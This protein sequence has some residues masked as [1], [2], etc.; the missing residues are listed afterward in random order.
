MGVIAMKATE[1]SLTAAEKRAL[2][3]S[4]FGLPE[5]RGWPLHDESHVRSAITNF[6]WCAQENQRELAKNIL[7][8]IRKFDMKDMQISEANPF[9]KYCPREWV[10]PRKK[11]ERKAKAA[12]G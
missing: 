1:A 6:H 9:S 12:E 2:K 11:P 8:A 3:D 7:K 10:V 4:D 5:Q